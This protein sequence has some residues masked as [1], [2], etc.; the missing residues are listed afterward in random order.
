M[1]KTSTY[2]QDHL[3]DVRERL[4]EAALPH[5]GFDGWSKVTLE[6]AIKDSGVEAGLA[7]QAFPRGGPDMAMEFHR[8]GDRD[9]DDDLRDTD[10]STMRIRERVTFCVRRRIELIQN[11]REAVRRGATLFALPIYAP[12]GARLVWETADL[13]WQRCGDLS[14]DY[15]WYTKRMILSGVYSSTVLYW[16]GDQDP[17]NAPTWEFLDRRIDDVM[18]FEKVKAKAKDNP[19]ARAVFALP[20]ALLGTIRAPGATR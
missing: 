17:D 14:T 2:Q 9:L 15:N 8:M 20:N 1:M 11:D 12:E 7:R 16:L 10:W 5:V 6:A 18:Q 3:R 19:L 4:V 13:I